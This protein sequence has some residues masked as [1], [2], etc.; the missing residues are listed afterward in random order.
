VKIHPAAVAALLAA[1]APAQTPDPSS[2]WPQFGGPTRDFKVATRGLAASW[3]SGGPRTLWSRNLGEGYSAIVSDGGSLYTMYRP[4]QASRTSEVVVALDAATGRTL[5][6][7]TYEAPLPSDV[8]VQYGPGPHSTPLLV[9]DRVVTVGSSGKLHAL[10]KRTGKVAWSHDL[11]QGMGGTV[12]GRGYSCSPLAYGGNIIVTVGGAG[13]AVVAFDAA[14][15]R[16]AWKNHSFRPG[17]SSPVLIR[18]DGQEQLV[19]FH[20]EGAAGMDPAGGPLY[21]D[22]KHTTDYGLNIAMPVW[23]EGNLLFLSS[24]YSGGSRMLRLTQ[25]GGKTNVQELWFTNKMRVHFANALRFGDRVVGSSGDFGPSFVTA[26]DVATGNVAWQ[27]RGFSKA[28]LLAADGKVV[29]LDE[30][31]TLALAVVTPGGLQV[32]GEAQVLDGRAWTVPTL[33]GTRLFVRDRAVV[34]A[35]ELG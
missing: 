23:G 34:K 35:L 21:W 33:L 11:W 5:W 25:A 14:T 28:T 20:S 6:E 24:A 29:L 16:I 10:D 12:Q 15:G 22:H 32:A 17:P 2:A 27:L 19:V 8:N 1:V 31:G 7:H 18:V 9:G 26:V 30:D 13:Q 3:P 4:T